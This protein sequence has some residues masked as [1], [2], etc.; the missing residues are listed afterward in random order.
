MEIKKIR[1]IQVSAVLLIYRVV[2]FIIEVIY[3]IGIRKVELQTY[4]Y[5]LFML[6]LW[7]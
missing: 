1:L 7:V 4:C 5:Y 3:M 6:K 2:G